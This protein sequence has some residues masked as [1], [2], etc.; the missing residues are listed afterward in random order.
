MK[1][2]MRE[3][4]SSIKAHRRKSVTDIRGGDAIS[5]GK[6]DKSRKGKTDGENEELKRDKESREGETDG[7]GQTQAER[8]SQTVRQ[9][10]FDTPVPRHQY[11]FISFL[12]PFFTSLLLFHAFF[13][14]L[15]LL[16]FSLLFPLFS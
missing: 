9:T 13:P 3:M 16:L 6:K 15:L 7:D 4:D 8:Q 2:T 12:L 5:K 14:L 10:G 11:F 1:I